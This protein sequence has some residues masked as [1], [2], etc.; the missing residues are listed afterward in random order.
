MTPA[1]PQ[2]HCDHECVCTVLAFGGIEG[3]RSPCDFS[4]C[5]HDTRTRPHPRAPDEYQTGEHDAMIAENVINAILT[6]ITEAQY[7]KS[8]MQD[9]INYIESLRDQT[10]GDEQHG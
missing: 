10:V 8:T 9:F 2:P 7:D 5:M 3:D 6:R 1:S 4:G